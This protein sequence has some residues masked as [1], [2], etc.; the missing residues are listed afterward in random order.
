MYHEMTPFIVLI[1]N[2]ERFKKRWF[3]A[4]AITNAYIFLKFPKWI[5]GCARW[6]G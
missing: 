5:L 6:S 3:V 2:K 1:C 4:M